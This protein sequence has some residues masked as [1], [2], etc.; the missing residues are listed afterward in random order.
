MVAEPLFSARS[1]ALC[2]R[3]AGEKRHTT[4]IACPLPP[5]A[6]MCGA[7]TY[8]RFGPKADKRALTIR[9]GLLIQIDASAL[10]LFGLTF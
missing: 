5:K 9:V 4:N 10:T 6:D 7:I 3:A 1:L 2:D 8:V